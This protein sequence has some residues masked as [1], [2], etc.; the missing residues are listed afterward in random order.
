[1]DQILDISEEH[2]RMNMVNANENIYI[3][4]T[5]ASMATLLSGNNPV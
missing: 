3:I 5:Y 1:M 2:P 4:L